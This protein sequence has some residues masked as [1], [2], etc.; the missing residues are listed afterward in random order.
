MVQCTLIP[1]CYDNDGTIS[2]S[3]LIINANFCP[4]GT[5]CTYIPNSGSGAQTCT[6]DPTSG[7]VTCDCSVCP[8]QGDI[9]SIFNRFPGI[10]ADDFQTRMDARAGLLAALQAYI[11]DFPPQLQG[12][13]LTMINDFINSIFAAYDAAED[14]GAGGGYNAG[15][16]IGLGLTTDAGYEGLDY[17]CLAW[18]RNVGASLRAAAG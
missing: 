1:Q 14:A 6:K 9:L 12:A 10:C 13:A 11:N 15:M 2:G 16:T 5:C 4:S 17:D 18:L 3:G 7:L 8:Q